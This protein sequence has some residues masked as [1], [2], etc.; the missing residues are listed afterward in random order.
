MSGLS[1]AAAGA[2]TFA[3][4]SGHTLQVHPFTARMLATI[5][6]CALQAFKREKVRFIRE[7]KDAYKDPDSAIDMVGDVQPGDLPA[8]YVKKWLAGSYDGKVLACWLSCKKLEPGL[9]REQFEDHF[10]AH[11]GK[12][13]ELSKLVADLNRGRLGNADGPPGEAAT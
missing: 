5:E 2:A 7:N 4:P 1:A 8:S 12:L 9:T 3:A 6:E 13:N 10:D 11:L